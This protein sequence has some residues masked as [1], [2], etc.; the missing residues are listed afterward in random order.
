[1]SRYLLNHLLQQW[2]TE[3]ERGGKGNTKTGIS[4]EWKKF[5][6]LNKKTFFMIFKAPVCYFS[7]NLTFSPNG[8]PSKT[9]KKM[10]FISSKKLFLFSRY[11]VFCNF[12]LPFYISQIQK[13]TWNWNNLWCYELACINLQMHFLA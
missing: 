10:S 8:S 13:D 1:M 6:R 12:T 7:S 9:I 5:F 2:L 4:Q 11:S 3:G